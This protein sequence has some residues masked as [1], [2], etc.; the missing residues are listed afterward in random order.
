MKR[1]IAYIVTSPRTAMNFLSGYLSDVSDRGWEV[2]LICASD[3]TIR[4]F[5]DKEGVDYREVKFTRDPSLVRDLAA[6]FRLIW[7][8]RSLSPDAVVFATP[9]ASLLGAVASWLTRVPVRV[10]EQWGLRLESV[11]GPMRKILFAMEWLTV[12]LATVVVANSSSLARRMESLK[13]APPDSIVTLG[14]G[15]S[16]GV[17]VDRFSLDNT[18]P[19]IDS[20]TAKFVS[21]RESFTIGFVGRIHPDKGVDVLLLAIRECVSN[22]MKVKCLLLGASEGF[23]LPIE[24]DLAHRIHYAGKVE[25]A[26]PYYREMDALVLMSKREGFPN[27]VLEAASMCVPAIVSDGTG[28]IDSVVDGTSGFVVPVQDHEQLAD[29]IQYLAL[30]PGERVAMGL[31]AR[32]RVVKHFG[33]TSVR[34]HHIDLVESEME[35]SASRS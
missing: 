34:A 23:E 3:P 15:S 11:R 27:V 10:Y 31:A 1:S 13:L 19:V 6:L 9:K 30:H 14:A 32:E 16:H 2:T 4:E 18:I 25:D 24:G 22:N 5:A 33:H 17:D 29:R 8:L 28:A 7:V 26:Q 35:S 20:S 21:Q 12:R